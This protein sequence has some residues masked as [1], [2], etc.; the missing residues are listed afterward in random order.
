MIGGARSR[1]RP[2]RPRS[3]SSTAKAAS[4]RSTS[5]RED[6]VSAAL[7]TAQ[8]QEVLPSGFQ[9]ITATDAAAEQTEQ[10]SEGLGF[11]RTALLVFAFVALFV[12]AFVIFNTFNIVVT[13]R[14]R[15][16]GLLR[17]LGASRGQ[18]FT[19]VVIESLV[20][21]LLGSAVGLAAGIG[22]AVLL[23]RASRRS[24]W[25]CPRPARDPADHDHRSV[26]GRYGRDRC[27]VGLPRASRFTGRA[28]RGDA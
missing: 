8:V 26:R 1:L 21:G 12:G 16:L 13:Q 9:A 7:V 2:P 10:V 20:I 19:S 27:G 6:G 15:E 25:S 11:L 3:A 17:A 24:G 14:T 23:K 5:S 28:D 4:I 18:V 22:L